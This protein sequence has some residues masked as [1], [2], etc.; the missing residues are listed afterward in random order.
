MLA[1]PVETD[2]EHR[3]WRKDVAARAVPFRTPVP[4]GL[5]AAQGQQH[6]SRPAADDPEAEIQGYVSDYSDDFDVHPMHEVDFTSPEA[7]NLLQAPVN[8]VADGGVP[9][10]ADDTSDEEASDEDTSDED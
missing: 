3:A 6:P 4:T 10:G 1:H 7:S 8:G 5:L 9:R 2:A